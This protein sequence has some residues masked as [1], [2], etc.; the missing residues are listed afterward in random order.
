MEPPLFHAHYITNTEEGKGQ[1]VTRSPVA[2]SSKPANIDN[3][4]VQIII[5]KLILL[6]QFRIIELFPL[7][8]R[9][10]L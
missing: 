5:A 8:E 6:T 2:C 7:E 9:I 3:R 1:S 10:I 4:E